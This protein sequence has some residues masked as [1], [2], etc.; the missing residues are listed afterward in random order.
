MPRLIAG[1]D[2]FGAAMNDRLGVRDSEQTAQLRFRVGARCVAESEDLI[3]VAVE[4]CQ[5]SG[6]L[7]CIP[8]GARWWVQATVGLTA[9]AATQI[10]Q[11]LAD[12]VSAQVLVCNDTRRSSNTDSLRPRTQALPHS[13]AAWAGVPVQCGE[14]GCCGVMIVVDRR[15]RAFAGHELALLRGVA[16][17]M[18]RMMELHTLRAGRLNLGSEEVSVSR[19]NRFARVFQISPDPIAILYLDTGTFADVNDAFLQVSGCARDEVIGRTT[20]EIGCA[21]VE[22][23]AGARV[24]EAIGRNGGVRNAEVKL[25]LPNGKIWV[26]LLSAE[27]IEM[28]SRRCLL[29]INRDISEIRRLEEQRLQAQKMDAIGRLAGGI[30]HDFNHV[31]TVIQ[32]NSEV[33]L[34]QSMALPQ[35]IRQPILEMRAAAERATS[36]NRQLLT[37][38]RQ[39]AL[40]L[41][42]VDLNRLIGSNERMLRSAVSEQVDLRLRLDPMLGRVRA[43]PGQISQVILDLVI[44]ARDAMPRGGSLSIETGNVQFSSSVPVGSS[45]VPAGRWVRMAVSDTGHGMNGGIQSRI[46]EPFFTTREEGQG[47]GLGLAMVYGIVKQSSGYIEISSEPGVGTT[48]EILLPRSDA[49]A[50]ARSEGHPSRPSLEGTETILLVENEEAIRLLCREVLEGHG[51]QVFT[52]ENGEDALHVAGAVHGPI[53]LLIADLVLPR[54]NGEVLAATLRQQQPAMAVLF[55]SSLS[56][57]LRHM[58]PAP[59]EDAQILQKPFS[60]AR[61]CRSVR[62]L[63]DRSSRAAW[64]Q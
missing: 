1:A 61:L 18:A 60:P 47:T 53:H 19:Q 59:C 11:L 56:G 7:F 63:L 39:Q 16:R 10:C 23:E 36:L 4:G 13:V 6:A 40:R 46:F 64:L 30:A 45:H 15:P 17:E 20:Q 52:A 49:P 2:A 34:S 22:E 9:A 35:G 37:F 57:H 27:V 12:P 43:D 33:L 26:G 62:D 5:A 48:F 50:P 54:V 51:Y 41:Q 29:V 42:D 25:R 31:L 58:N 14:S 32:G 55:I 21:W 24:T 44:N 38:S 3:G 28:E 8:E